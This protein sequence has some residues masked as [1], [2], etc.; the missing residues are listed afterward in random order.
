MSTNFLQK[1][2]QT[3]GQS[4][5]LAKLHS[6]TTTVITSLNRTTAYFTFKKI[7]IKEIRQHLNYIIKQT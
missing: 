1:K 7:K 3:Q 2:R 6:T 4:H 5:A